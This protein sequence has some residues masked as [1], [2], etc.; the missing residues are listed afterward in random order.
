MCGGL[1]SGITLGVEVI[2]GLVTF[3]IYFLGNL[4]IALL[5]WFFKILETRN[6]KS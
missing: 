2:F 5:D 4:V 1:C 3:L 6:T